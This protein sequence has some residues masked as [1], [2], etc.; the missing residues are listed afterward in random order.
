MQLE[1]RLNAARLAPRHDD[2]PLFFIPPLISGPRAPTHQPHPLGDPHTLS[3]P[4][5]SKQE[6]LAELSKQLDSVGLEDE[7]EDEVRGPKIG[8]WF[9]F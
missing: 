4:P 6:Q 5:S 1:K 7:F 9:W 8:L 3:P 2:A